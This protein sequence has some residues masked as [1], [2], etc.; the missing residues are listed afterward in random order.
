ML[1]RKV[2]KKITQ[3]FEKRCVEALVLLMCFITVVGGANGVY[4]DYYNDDVTG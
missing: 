1:R 3:V 4:G 2:K